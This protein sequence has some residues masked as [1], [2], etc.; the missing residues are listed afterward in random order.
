MV[1]GKVELLPRCIAAWERMVVVCRR[2]CERLRSPK[3]MIA[4]ECTHT[5]QLRDHRLTMHI[6]GDVGGGGGA[7]IPHKKLEN[8]C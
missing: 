5:L 3:P 8:T 4:V 7:V 6:R 2:A 1:Q